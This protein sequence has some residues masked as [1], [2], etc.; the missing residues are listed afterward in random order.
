[1]PTSKD[2]QKFLYALLA[3]AV[4]VAE[5]EGAMDY[6]SVLFLPLLLPIT[7]LENKLG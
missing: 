3:P 7:L 5:T 1:M 2:T 4:N 6:A